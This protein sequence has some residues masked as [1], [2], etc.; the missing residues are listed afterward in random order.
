VDLQTK[1]G[2]LFVYTAGKS[3]NV[4]HAERD[5]LRRYRPG[6]LIY[7]TGQTAHVS[8]QQIA[9]YMADL[10]ALNADLGLPGPLIVCVDHRGGDSS[11]LPPEKGGLEFPAPIAQAALAEDAEQAGVAIGAAIARDV[12]D[13]GYNLNLS[14][15]A[16]F[17]ERG[18]IKQFVFGN[19]MM[20][21][22]PQVNAALSVGLIRGMQRAGMRTTYCVFPGGYGSLAQDPH[23]FLGVINAD[24]QEL[25]EKYFVAPRAAFA[26][27]ADAVMLSHFA[28]P[29]L[30]PVIQPATF[31]RRIVEE[32]LRGELG[33]D[34]LVMTD[35][36]RMK[37]CVAAAGSRGEA[38][39]RAVEAGADIILCASWEEQM[40]VADAVE[41]GRIPLR[42]IDEAVDRVLALKAKLMGHVPAAR[43][44][45][46]PVDQGEMSYWFGR[47]MT[48]LRRDPAWRPLAT[49]PVK[50]IAAVAGWV[51]FLDAAGAVLGA[52]VRALRVPV[53]NTRGEIADFVANT[54]DMVVN[55]D[56]EIELLLQLT[57]E[58]EIVLFGTTTAQ[59][60][61]L[62]RGMEQA[63]RSV[64]VVHA[65]RVFETAQVPDLS[66]VLLSYSH[67][68]VACRKAIEVLAGR[69]EAAGRLPV[70]LPHAAPAGVD[71]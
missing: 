23:H 9:R 41:R 38:A 33:F 53:R 47:S 27:G 18:D 37:G 59:D 11:L 7:P 63:G 57:A 24:R 2:Q 68:P 62:A 66:T 3:R 52:G 69:I 6:G 58:D 70:P 14:P 42:R 45:P 17:L 30:D 46:D 10:Q 26:A 61:R 51:D 35:S 39:I 5:F 32:V 36:I 49:L 50:G 44:G 20:G 64:W 16:D 28:F 60:L 12:L 56:E 29:A 34:G 13:V 55:E 22:D 21:A 25:D 8:R 71:R 65:G 19:S 67:G 54:R 43:S 31:S 15:Y 4:G 48:W 1:I 40:A